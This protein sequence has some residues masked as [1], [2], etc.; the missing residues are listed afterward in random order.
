MIITHWA[1]TS[2]VLRWQALDKAEKVGISPLTLTELE[3]IKT[4]KEDNKIKYDARE[5]IRAILKSESFTTIFVD[6]N[7]I[8]K[9]LNKYNFLSNI[10]DHRILCAA[11]L[12]AIK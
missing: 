11:E 12:T 10:N 4:S 6:E 5:A 8:D 7:K 9:M 2:A 3:H 1:D